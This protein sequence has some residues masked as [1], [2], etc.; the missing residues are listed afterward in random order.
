VICVAA[1]PHFNDPRD[2]LR[3]MSRV[4]KTGAE[5]VIAHLMSREELAKHHSTHRNVSGDLLPNDTEMKSLLSSAGLSVIQLI[6]MPGRYL[7]KATKP[8]NSAA[9]SCPA[10]VE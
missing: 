8:G 1:F 2:A 4:A 7:A 9:G 5:I 6:D 10:A 3:E